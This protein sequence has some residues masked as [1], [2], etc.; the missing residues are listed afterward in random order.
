MDKMLS[1]IILG[2]L[3]TILWISYFH[4]KNPRKQPLKEIVKI[5]ILGSL[6]VI[7]VI[8][9]HQWLLKKVINQL[10][11]SIQ[12]FEIPF[13]ASAL[14]LFLI[15]AFI[16][17]FIFIFA[18]AHSLLVRAFYK[19]PLKKSFSIVHNRLYSIVPILA[20]FTLFLV[21][22]GFLGLGFKVSFVTSL[23]GNT[24]IFALL[25]EYFKYIINPFLV[26]KKVNSVGTAM[27]H[28]LYVGLAFAFIENS[29]F[30]YVNFNNENFWD[31]IIFR[32][33]ITTLVH[34]CASGIIG[35]FYGLSLFS[36]S[37]IANYEIE[38][39]NYSMPA[40][41]KNFLKKETVFR[42]SA[43]TQGFIFAAIFHA[44]FNILINLNMKALATTL[45]SIFT[46]IIVLLL[47]SK[48]TQIQYGIIG[49][50]TISEE[51]YEKLRLQISVLQHTKEI[52]KM[53]KTQETSTTTSSS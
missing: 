32:S 22:E 21:I 11:D 41:M 53:H 51:E 26:Y 46:I 34:V 23:I 5:F 29:L 27:V 17:A 6:S 40:W 37:M 4:W 31:I 50:K 2:G 8:L 38:K 10:I 9:F 43:V 47:Q 42:S 39:S 18:S 48:T 15:L 36:E 24:I 28:A 12:L 14:E 16:L 52:Q 19:L 30:F 45:V 13:F 1:I 35:Y 7:P 25:E 49:G 3:P 20:F 44:L 33:I